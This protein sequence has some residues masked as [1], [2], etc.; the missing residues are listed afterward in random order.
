MSIYQDC[1]NGNP[2]ACSKIAQMQIL[3]KGIQELKRVIKFPKVGPD[4]VPDLL[5]DTVSNLSLELIRNM[6]KGEPSPQPAIKLNFIDPA[7][8]NSGIDKK[9]IASSLAQFSAAMKK[10]QTLIESDIHTIN[11]LK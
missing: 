3:A 10:L 8:L 5:L 6:F 2:T 9:L 7:L 4:P 1:L 11:R